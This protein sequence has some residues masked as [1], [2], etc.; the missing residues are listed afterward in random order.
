MSGW[1][2]SMKRGFVLILMMVATQVYASAKDDFK[3][4]VSYFKSAN[5]TSAVKKFE[6]ARKQ[7]MHSTALYYNLGSAYYKLQNYKKAEQYFIEIRKSPKMKS[8]AEYNLGLIAVKQ[9]NKAE[10]RGYFNSVVRNSK[11]KKMI[12]LAKQQLKKIRPKKKPWSVYLN[13]AIGYDDNI[14]FAPAGIRTEESAN[15]F[16]AM[17]SADYLFTGKKSNGWTGEAM[18]YTIKYGDSGNPNISKGSFD[19]D[20]FGVSLKKTQKLANWN[21]QFKAGFDKLTY[22]PLDYQS[23]LKLEARGKLKTS[24][25]DRFYLRYRYENISSD[26]FRYDYLEGWRQKIRGEFR[27]YN[28]S[29]SMQL[30]YELELNDRKDF[31]STATGN[32]FSYSPTRHTFRG[33]YTA[34]LNNAWQLGGDLAYRMSSYPSTTTQSRTDNRWKAAVYSNYRFDKSMKLKLKLEYT[35]N[36]STDT[37]YVYDRNVISVS[38]NKLF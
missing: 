4:G 12:Y 38:L 29:N 36:S 16:D 31:I 28:K 34:V 7:G 32:E 18:L 17:L 5:Y 13:G 27:R 20:Q 15:F 35:D 19:Q 2:K 30:Y 3:Q 23:I 8:L 22:G 37:I 9:N 10:A 6:N 26:N 24:R 25:T 1:K 11:D 21:T 14:N 33:K